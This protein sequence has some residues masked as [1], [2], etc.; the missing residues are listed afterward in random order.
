MCPPG[1][2]LKDRII[3][4]EN[5]NNILQERI[6]QQ[7]LVKIIKDALSPDIYVQMGGLCCLF[8]AEE[9][10]PFDTPFVY[11]TDQDYENSIIDLRQNDIT[12]EELYI[13]WGDNTLEIPSEFIQLGQQICQ[14]L[15]STNKVLVEWSHNIHARIKV[16]LL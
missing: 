4:S 15:L 8:C 1:I 16:I 3:E 13:A 11:T 14:K 10:M 12:I 2:L 9:D 7:E 5:E 6:N